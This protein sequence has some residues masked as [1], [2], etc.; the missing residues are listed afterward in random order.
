MLQVLIF[1]LSPRNSMETTTNRNVILQ[2]LC[3]LSNYTQHYM[4]M[5]NQYLCSYLIK[6]TQLKH[7]THFSQL[8]FNEIVAMLPWQP[9]KL[10]QLLAFL[11]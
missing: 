7:V 2:S 9:F 6:S 11:T 4:F 8:S 3:L 10:L 1:Q 5:I